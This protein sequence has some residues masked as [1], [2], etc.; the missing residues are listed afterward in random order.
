MPSRHPT[1][2][3]FL[4]T[5]ITREL[6]T[7]MCDHY[8]GYLSVTSRLLFRL[9]DFIF[10]LIFSSSSSFTGPPRFLKIGAFI[11]SV[12]SSCALLTEASEKNKKLWNTK[13][14]FHEFLPK[15]SMGDQILS[16][17][18]V[19]CSTRRSRMGVLL[20]CMTRLLGYFLSAVFFYYCW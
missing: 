2:I 12:F 4:F 3:R 1:Y 17:F 14:L 15:K 5:R 6:A 20:G 9:Q 19:Y 10:C 13:V 7:A 18:F 11:C 16:L 8:G